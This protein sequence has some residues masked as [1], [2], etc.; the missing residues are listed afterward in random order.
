MIHNKQC[1]F[2]ISFAAAILSA[3][4]LAC[5]PV[6][7]ALAAE[8][9]P[10]QDKN[11]RSYCNYKLTGL[12]ER[13]DAERIKKFFASTL[14]YTNPDDWELSTNLGYSAPTTFATVNP[15]RLCLNSPGGSFLEALEIAKI[16]NSLSYGTVVP[17]DA[18]CESACALIFLAGSY[19]T[20]GESYVSDRHIHATA[21]LGFHA[22]SLSLSESLGDKFDRAQITSAYEVA[23]KSMAVIQESAT[24]LNLRSSLLAQMLGTPPSDMFYVDTVGKAVRWHIGV[25]GTKIPTELGARQ[26]QI[27]CKAALESEFDNQGEYGFIGSSQSGREPFDGGSQMSLVRSGSA[28]NLN[29][30]GQRTGYLTEAVSICSFSYKAGYQNGALKP[31]YLPGRVEFVDENISV[32][33]GPHS[34]YSPDIKLAY[35][36]LKSDD[37]FEPVAFEDDANGTERNTFIGGTCR[38]ISNQRISDAEFCKQTQE[39]A[40]LVHTWPSGSR[41]VILQRGNQLTING[42]RARLLQDGTSGGSNAELG[43]CHLNLR[44]QNV[45]C[46][47]ASPIE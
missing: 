5:S 32:A 22:P 26:V 29:Y 44:S 47:S 1:T 42:T 18:R 38:V 10:T 24:I 19:L 6:S 14:G 30:K 12:I 20:E 37:T 34:L 2:I 7:S 13:G 46:F 35:I 25:Y 17:R 27:S 16:L 4:V 3:I 11:H 9:T 15:D 40:A 28:R 43:R 23:I 31:G 8:L 33:L 21:K 41:T 45:F 36:A 39:A